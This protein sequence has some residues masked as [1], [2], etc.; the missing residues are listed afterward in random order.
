MKSKI[1]YYRDLVVEIEDLVNMTDSLKNFIQNYVNDLVDIPLIDIAIRHIISKNIYTLAF[2]RK[3]ER[4]TEWEYESELKKIQ[5]DQL[6]YEEEQKNIRLIQT[7]KMEKD[8]LR[9]IREE[10]FAKK[11]FSALFMDTLH[12]HS[13]L[14]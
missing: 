13:Y 10:E 6:K 1:Q 8:R 14:Y 7:I 4:K 9:K 11:L 3:H 12:D 2:K 5:K